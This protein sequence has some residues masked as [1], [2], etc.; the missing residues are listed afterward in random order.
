MFFK[1][2]LCIVKGD[3]QDIMEGCLFGALPPDLVTLLIN[4]FAITM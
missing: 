3:Y 4:V 2:E 1:T